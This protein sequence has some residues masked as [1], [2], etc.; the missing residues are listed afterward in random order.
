MD[1]SQKTADLIKRMEKCNLS[2]Y[3]WNEAKIIELLKKSYQLFNLDFPKK[4]SIHKDI[5]DEK[6]ALSAWSAW[7]AWSASSASSAL[8]AWS[9]WSVSLASSAWSASSACDWDWYI[10][11]FE[12]SQANKVDNENDKKYIQYHELMLEAAENGLGYFVEWEDTLYLV[13]K[14]QVRIDERNRFHSEIEPAIQWKDGKK[15]YFLNG[16]NLEKDLWQK[17]VNKTIPTAEAIKLENQEHRTLALQYIGGE[18]LEQDLGGVVKCRD[19]YGQLIEL[20]KLQDF[21]GKNY[22]Y[23]KAIDP[24]KGKYIYLRT[25]PDIKTPTEAMTRAYRLEQWNLIYQPISRT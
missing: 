10:F 15:F 12:F 11:T 6:F 14:P 19:I 17:I 4:I 18:K 25:H 7:S 21:N 8:S 9:A 22:L 20:T 16:V 13:P 3:V 23:Y 5:F 1:F 2:P 24:S